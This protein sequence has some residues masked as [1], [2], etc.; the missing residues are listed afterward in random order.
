MNTVGTVIRVAHGDMTVSEHQGCKNCGADIS[1]PKKLEESRKVARYIERHMMDADL[2][3]F[4][5][6][7]CLSAWCAANP[8]F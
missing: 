2:G 5:N 4:C 7:T 8:L 1:D 6:I 3:S